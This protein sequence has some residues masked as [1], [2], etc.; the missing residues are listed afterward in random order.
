MKTFQDFLNES[1]KLKTEIYHSSNMQAEV[2]NTGKSF[3]V[4]TKPIVDKISDKQKARIKAK[5]LTIEE[6][7]D[8]MTTTK[9]ISSMQSV[10]N[11]LERF[12]FTTKV[13]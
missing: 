11:Y 10:D 12:G 13:Q 1:S 7:V 3:K 9:R 4:I 8:L 6:F 5:G 2:I